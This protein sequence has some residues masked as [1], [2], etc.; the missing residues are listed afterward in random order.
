MSG[1]DVSE[2]LGL[3]QDFAASAEEVT[4]A[5]APAV[6][7]AALAVKQDMQSG[8]RSRGNPGFRAVATA[9]SYDLE[10][11]GRTV[12]AT[13]GPEK[14]SGALANVAIWG[15][16]KGGGGGTDP[17]DQGEAHADDLGE[18]AMTALTGRW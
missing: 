8:Y 1:S 17:L 6:S 16:S 10:T 5:L 12:S 3:A 18:Y 14:P 13:V 15:T 2:L 9:V 11:R 7:K 4:D